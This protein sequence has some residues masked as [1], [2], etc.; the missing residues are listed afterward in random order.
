[1]TSNVRIGIHDLSLTECET[2][3]RKAQ[4]LAR[5]CWKTWTK[6]RSS[7]ITKNHASNTSID[8]TLQF[9]EL[10]DGSVNIFDNGATRSQGY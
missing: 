10:K 7:F 4:R 9:I 3:G 8:T 5:D 2:P 1:V 6:F